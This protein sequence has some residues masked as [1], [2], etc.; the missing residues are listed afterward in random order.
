MEP[1]Q[2][3]YKAYDLTFLWQWGEIGSVFSEWE[4]GMHSMISNT[5]QTV[6]SSPI[7]SPAGISS[8]VRNGVFLYDTQPKNTAD[9][10]TEYATVLQARSLNLVLR[11]MVGPLII[12][13]NTNP[14]EEKPTDWD[15]LDVHVFQGAYIIRGGVSRIIY[16]V[17]AFSIRRSLTSKFFL[18]LF[19]KNAIRRALTEL[20]MGIKLFHTALQ[21]RCEANL[22]KF[23]IRT[24]ISLQ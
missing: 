2:G 11:S 10:Q 15:F 7:S 19:R 6:I 14:K 22:L 8:V 17:M 23:D 1:L 20:E 3:L 18:V 24:T 13:I 9:L 12:Y 4:I 5:T 16:N 21:T